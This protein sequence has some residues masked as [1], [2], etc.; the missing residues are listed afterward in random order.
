[1][2]LECSVVHTLFDAHGHICRHG[3]DVNNVNYLARLLVRVAKTKAMF[4][5]GGRKRGRG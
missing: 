5:E 1:M 4:V 3:Q 2:K